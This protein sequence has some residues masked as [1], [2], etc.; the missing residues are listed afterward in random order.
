MP[1][2]NLKYIFETLEKEF[3]NWETELNYS[4]P[5]Q[6]LVAVILSAQTTDKQVNKVTSKFFDY[7]KNPQDVVNLWYEKREQMIK[8]VNYFRNKA[9]NIYK[10]AQILSE[11]KIKKNKSPS[12]S[13]L[14]FSIFNKYDYIIPYKLED[15]L[16]LPWVW[17]KTAKVILHILYNQPVVAVDTHV[18][19]VVN[20]LWIVQTKSPLET[21]KLLEKILPLKYKKIAHH[22]LIYF[23]RYFCTAR[24]PKCDECKFTKICKYYSQKL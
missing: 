21:S 14:N 17:E 8:S 4:T 16:K 13:I 19:R 15:L 11:Q 18:F 10:T 9:K 2:T 23:G 1:K 6:L 20:K 3:Y 7:V 22:S 24:K 5:F 12:F